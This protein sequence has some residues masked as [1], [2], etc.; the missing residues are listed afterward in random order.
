MVGELLKL[1]RVP[2]GEVPKQVWRLP[3]QITGVAKP[4]ER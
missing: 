4:G 1:A 2:R 3:F